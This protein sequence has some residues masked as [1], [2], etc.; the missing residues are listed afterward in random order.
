M[1][2]ISKMR[3]KNYLLVEISYLTMY[4][5]SLV[6]KIAKF[7]YLNPMHPLNASK[8]AQYSIIVAAEGDFPASC[9]R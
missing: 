8:I 5:L 9:L 1:P 2:F 7:L 6:K 3:K 4:I